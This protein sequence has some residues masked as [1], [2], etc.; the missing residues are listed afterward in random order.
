MGR[1]GLAISNDLIEER[2]WFIRLFKGMVHGEN[3]ETWGDKEEIEKWFNYAITVLRD[4]AVFKITGQENM[5][6]NIDLKDSIAR[7]EQNHRVKGYNRKLHKINLFE[8][9]SQI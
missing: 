1:P 3:K 2:D 9:V 7:H 6:I 8:G 4:T 5:L